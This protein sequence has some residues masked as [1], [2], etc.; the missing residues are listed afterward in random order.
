M[1]SL[2]AWSVIDDGGSE[3][4]GGRSLGKIAIAHEWISA[5]AGSE[6]VFE[7]LAQQFPQADL[8]ALTKDPQ[9]EFDSGG[10]R[11]STTVLDHL[12]PLRDRRSLSLPLMPLAWRLTRS[13]VSYDTVI[14]SSH[15]C[16]KGFWPG[17]DALH[18]CY[19]HAPMRY[20]WNPEIDDRGRGAVLA[21][22]RHALRT[23]DL[24]STR[25]VDSFA[26]NSSA[27]AARI[28]KFYGRRARVINPPVDVAFFS[29]A[30]RAAK[31]EGL[32][33]V[34]R[35]IPY[36]GHDIAIAAAAKVDLPITI[37]GRGPD[38]QRLR[39]VAR[40]SGA[41]A[42]FVTDATDDDLRR[43]VSSAIGLVFAADEDFG[44]VPVEAQ[45][46]G[47]PV[48]GP[49][50]GGLLDTVVHRETG[51]LADELSVAG[52]ADSCL[53]LLDLRLDASRCRENAD[54]FSAARFTRQIDEWLE[55]GR[56]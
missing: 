30:P 39:D 17:R 22:A 19:V 53:R 14:T 45:A 23:W 36:K 4:V 52:I 13:N 56:S 27:V 3:R 5:R 48:V 37:V 11:V 18:F 51:V 29:S 12:G 38:E 34:G 47:T 31:R 41:R 35:L 20:V 28:E 54:R 7:G 1:S 16:V 6:K 42:T 49:A 44:I 40:R 33:S 25:W 50:V 32:V 43:H 46:A 15:A 9:V 55:A 26:A 8:Y 24:S 21:P 10:R 2:Y